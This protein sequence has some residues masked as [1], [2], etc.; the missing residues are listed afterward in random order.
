MLRERGRQEMYDAAAK[1]GKA[2][3]SGATVLKSGE[4]YRVPRVGTGSKKFWA[5]ECVTWPR[6]HCGN[7]TMSSDSGPSMLELTLAEKRALR[8]ICLRGVVKAET[9]GASH[10]KNWKKVGL[11][12]AYFTKERV[13][14]A[15]MPTPRAKAAFRFLVENNQFYQ[16]YLVEQHRRLDKGEYMTISSYDLFIKMYGIECAMYPHLYPLSC[17]TDTAI[18]K[19]YR[20]K[21]KDPSN[22]TVSIG[23]SWT[24]KV[25]SSVRVYGEQRDLTFFF[26]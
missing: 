4:L 3:G 8:I 26:V 23:K 22:R 19:L 24:R 18:L 21:S 2:D 16:E 25:L 13:T 7:F 14:E 5:K 6:Y 20:D 17:F 15:S 9:F 11:S 10:H 12:V 1:K